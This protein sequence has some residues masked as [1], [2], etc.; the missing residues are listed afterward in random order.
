MKFRQFEHLSNGV[1]DEISSP[2]P[3]FFPLGVLCALF[4]AGIWLF[5]DILFSA[6]ILSIHSRTMAGGFLWSFIV[7]FLMTAVPRMSGTESASWWEIFFS[8][9]LILIQIF[10]AWLIDQKFFFVTGALLVLFLAFYGGRRL[11]K[12]KVKLP[13]FFSHIGLAFLMA[14]LGCYAYASGESSLGMVCYFVGPILLLIMGIGTR[15]FSFL[16]GLPSEFE[17]SKNRFKIPL[18]HL[19]GIVMVL[20][21][22]LAGLGFEWAYLGL[23][24]LS[25][26]YLVFIWRI[27]RRS[28]RPSPPN[29]GAR[30]VATS[31]PLSFF[32]CWLVPDMQITWFHLLFVGCF[33]LLNFSVATRVTL[34][35]GAYPID[36]ELK[37]PVLWGLIV[38]TLLSLGFRV[39]LDLFGRGGVGIHLL[40]LA[41]LFWIGAILSWCYSFFLRIFKPG[42]LDRPS[43]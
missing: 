16:S 12:S 23:F 5:Q 3:D 9:G 42:S 8:L 11:S 36:L 43:C 20:F 17:N 1:G 13:I 4:G 25:L 31:I 6:P 28:D 41:V 33:S 35:H 14:L 34:A 26:F 7:G 30:I 10:Q 32:L 19:S 22:V 18:F 27:F 38:L 2:L 21:L 39:S 40:H 15:F 24:F 37:T 29:Y